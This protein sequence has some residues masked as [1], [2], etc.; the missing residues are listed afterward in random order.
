[1]Q[2]GKKKKVTMISMYSTFL[3]EVGLVTV[4]QSGSNVGVLLAL[5]IM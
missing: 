1:M 3:L 2:K 4:V 5:C